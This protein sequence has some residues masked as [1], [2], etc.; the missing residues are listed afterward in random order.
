M[1]KKRKTRRPVIYEG[2]LDLDKVVAP[3]IRASRNRAEHIAPS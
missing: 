1:P 3:E 2:S